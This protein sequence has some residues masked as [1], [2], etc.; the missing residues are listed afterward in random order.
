MILSITDDHENYE[1]FII[2]KICRY[3][4]Y[5]NN[6]ECYGLGLVVLKQI[7]HALR[8]VYHNS[9]FLLSVDIILQIA[10]DLVHDAGRGKEGKGDCGYFYKQI[11][12]LL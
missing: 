6:A 12:N 7:S 8:C 11:V 10:F 5:D 2:T 9:Q 1:M 4:V 3:T